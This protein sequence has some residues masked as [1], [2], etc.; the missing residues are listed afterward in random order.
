M[1]KPWGRLCKLGNSRP[2]FV[3]KSRLVYT[4]YTLHSCVNEA[5]E[6]ALAPTPP[7]RFH[8]LLAFCWSLAY[9]TDTYRLAWLASL[10]EFLTW[11]HIG[12][13]PFLKEQ[14]IFFSIVFSKHLELLVLLESFHTSQNLRYLIIPENLKIP[15]SHY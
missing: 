3:C 9:V 15:V 13:K 14:S 8:G 12:V 4:D 10:E 1:S 7:Q 6:L 5:F 11:D 2:N